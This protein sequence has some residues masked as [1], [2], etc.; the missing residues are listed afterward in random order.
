MPST[1]PPATRG[2]FAWRGIAAQLMAVL[3]LG[4]RGEIPEHGHDPGDHGGIIVAVGADHYHVEAIFA[5]GQ[6]RL[7]TLGQDQ[8][9]P[10]PVPIQTLTA[11]LRV[12]GQTESLSMT[13]DAVPLAGDP[14]GQTSQFTGKLPPGMRAGRVIV[15]VPAIQFADERFRFSFMTEPHTEAVMPAKVVDAAERE[16]YLTPKGSYTLADIEANGRQTAS[17]RYADFKSAH[18]PHPVQGD[19]ICPITGTKA[20]AAC[21]WIVAGAEHQFCCPPCID[22]FVR[23]AKEQPEK[24]QPPA[25]YFK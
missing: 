14:Q 5:E 10:T 1:P 16:L 17:E 24:V 7:F 22:E 3:C 21:T 19:R 12:E 25:S 20:N 18:D 13:L 9:R 2:R 23:W 4:C 8:T 15:I 6:L 11:F